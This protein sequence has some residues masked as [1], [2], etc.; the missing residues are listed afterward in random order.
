MKI[1]LDAQLSPALARWISDQFN[2]DTSHIRD[3]GLLASDD[4]EIFEAAREAGVVLITKDRDFVDLLSRYGPPPQV[5]W[6][7]C[8]NTSNARMK[9]ILRSQFLPALEIL[10][11]KEPLLEIRDSLK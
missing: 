5:I 1:W 6:L 2:V 11:A 7:T 4:S 10:G 3:H 8:G 9:E